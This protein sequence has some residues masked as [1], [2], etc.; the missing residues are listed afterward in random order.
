MEKWPLFDIKVQQRSFHEIFCIWRVI[1]H[2][3]ASLCKQVRQRSAVCNVRK[4]ECNFSKTP[5][6][7]FEAQSISLEITARSREVV[8]SHDRRRL[9]FWCRTETRICTLKFWALPVLIQ[10]NASTFLY[11]I[12][13][14]L[15]KPNQYH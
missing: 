10:R 14:S 3:R 9:L 7:R 6:V 8:A 12:A 11:S 4:K 5:S 2:A 13:L 15:N 1:P